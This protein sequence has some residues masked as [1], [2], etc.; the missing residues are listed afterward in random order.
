MLSKVLSDLFSDFDVSCF[1][2]YMLGVFLS[3]V[4]I[5]K[6]PNNVFIQVEK[7]V[8][9][10]RMFRQCLGSTLRVSFYN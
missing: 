8:A 3:F 7:F 6:G 5:L 2:R 4:R 9:S 1:F 10:G